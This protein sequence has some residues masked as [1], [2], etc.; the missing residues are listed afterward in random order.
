LKLCTSDANHEAFL[1]ATA[2]REHFQMLELCLR[3]K[4]GD[5]LDVSLSGDME[6]I[7]GEP[8]WI[9]IIRDVTDRK[10]AEQ[11]QQSLAHL[12]RVSTLGELAGSLGHEL[13]QPLAAILSNAQAATR[14]L[15]ASPS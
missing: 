11:A 9:F 12:T 7:G 13:N 6:D 2:T 10:R 5:L 3:K 4:G 14:F 8:C 1:A 15:E